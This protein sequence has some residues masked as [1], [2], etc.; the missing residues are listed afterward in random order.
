[1]LEGT[2]VTYREPCAA[3]VRA[4]TS[5]HDIDQLIAAVATL[6]GGAPAPVPYE[7]DPAQ[8]TSSR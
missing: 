3:S 1:V 4:R 8:A 6:A 7:Q 2:T 5:G